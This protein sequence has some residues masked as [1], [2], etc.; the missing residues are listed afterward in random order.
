MLFYTIQNANTITVQKIK[1][2]QYLPQA[3]NATAFHWKI[4]QRY[5]N[6]N[7]WYIYTLFFLSIYKRE[8][9]IVYVMVVNRTETCFTLYTIQYSVHSLARQDN[10]TWCYQAQEVAA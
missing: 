9:H 5:F 1:L 10:I 6:V 4:K 7:M 2:T 3:H 8:V